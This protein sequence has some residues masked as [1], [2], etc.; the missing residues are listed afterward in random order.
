MNRRL[1]PL[2]LLVFAGCPPRADVRTTP[3]PDATAL[4]GEVEA[5]EARV[6]S[7]QS[8]AKVR[9]EGGGKKGNLTAFVAVAAPASV[10]LEVLDFFGR[11]SAILISDGQRFVLYQAES[12]VWLP[13]PATAENLARILPVPLPPEEL[14]AMLLG[15]APRLPDAQPRLQVDPEANAFRIDLRDGD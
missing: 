6:A 3:A 8:Q 10:H 4:L 14:V 13:G 7:L 1:W 15:R 12:G 11:P 2:F 9:V 5:I